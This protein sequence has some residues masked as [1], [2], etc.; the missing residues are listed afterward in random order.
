MRII[1]GIAK[2]T[3][4]AAP[5]GLDTRPTSDMAKESLFNIL[6]GEIHGARFLDLFCG[7]GAIGL[8]A[9]SR[10]AKEAV[11]V[12]NA[13]HAISALLQNLEKTKLAD[14]AE[15]LRMPVA[16]A[17]DSLSA[18]GR[19]FDIIFLDPP[20]DT[21]LLQETIDKLADTNILAKHGVII[22]ETDSKLHAMP[23]RL[24]VTDTRIYGRSCFMFINMENRKVCQ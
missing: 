15:V 11:F 17:L 10:G 16:K 6:S 7:S 12:E 22:A 19:Q 14:Y 9:I 20:Y 8:E 4:L 13:A 1:A 18:S 5:K 24:E 21:T 23:L 3:V 2:R